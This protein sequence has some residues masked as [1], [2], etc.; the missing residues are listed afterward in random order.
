MAATPGTVERRVVHLTGRAA[1]GIVGTIVVLI[2]LRR[3]FV[4]AHRPISWAVAC[5]IAAILLDPIVDRLAVHL[6]RVP[7]VLLTFL[8]IGAIGV[9]TAYLVADGIQGAIDRLERAAPQAAARIEDRED[10][11]GEVATDFELT[12][13]VTSFVRALNDRTTNGNDVLRSTA[14]TA[15]SYLVCAVLTLFL[16]TYGPRMAQSALEQDPDEARRKRIGKVVGPAIAR[17]RSGIL[18]TGAIAFTIGL[19]S[20]G[21]AELLGLPAAAAVGLTASVFALLPHVGILLGSVPLLLLS[22][23]FKTSTTTILLALAV[24]VLQFVDSRYVRSWIA[25]RSVEI[26]LFVPF[27]VALLGYE[28]YG[29]GGA[30]YGVAIAIGALA[31]LDQ[32]ESKNDDRITAKAADPVKKAPAKKAPAKKA[33]AAKK[34]T[35]RTSAAKAPAKGR[36]P[37]A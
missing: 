32:L 10:R 18:Y 1:L 28:V 29:I 7:A 26:G 23:G 34:A 3:V 2:V 4:A 27:V 35:T 14:G 19:V 20:A 15:P 16:M 36:R 22:L 8:A 33:A 21:V 12:D 31:I 24:V 37:T 9:G 13:R 25:T 5:G 6:R 30:A 11:V 17:A